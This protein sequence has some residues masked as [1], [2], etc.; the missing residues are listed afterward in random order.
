[1]LLFD[2]WL[3]PDWFSFG[4]LPG[5]VQHDLLAVMQVYGALRQVVENDLADLFATHIDGTGAPLAAARKR[6]EVVRVL[7]VAFLSSSKGRIVKSI[8]LDLLPPE[9]LVEFVGFLWMNPSHSSKMQ[10][11]D[12]SPYS[13]DDDEARTQALV[14]V[15]RLLDVGDA[16]FATEVR[17]AMEARWRRARTSIFSRSCEVEADDRR[18]REAFKALPA[19]LRRFVLMLGG[20][21]AKKATSGA[22]TNRAPTTA[23]FDI[24]EYQK[25]HPLLFVP[26]VALVELHR[27][28]AADT[29][30]VVGGLDLSD[31]DFRRVSRARNDCDVRVLQRI[32]SIDAAIYSYVHI[33]AIAAGS[34]AKFIGSG[35]WKKVTEAFER[36]NGAGL[37][38]NAEALRDG[39][40]GDVSPNFVP[41]G[42][43]DFALAINLMS[44]CRRA[45]SE[46]LRLTQA[47]RDVDVAGLFAPTAILKNI[48]S[49]PAWHSRLTAMVEQHG[50]LIQAELK[51]LAAGK[52]LTWDEQKSTAVD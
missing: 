22:A 20:E 12:N 17:T 37:Q 33:I 29:L 32:V 19:H 30:A 36:R 21:L 8:E 25:S 13:F 31:Y 39:T 41:G 24:V 45:P 4:R 40:L 38:M 14:E 49:G 27:A 11:L 28:L 43:R 50:Q 47:H 5:R 7:G 34:D 51:K 2:R 10:S 6:E 3:N 44:E 15:S 46:F 42:K 23:P 35:V 18:A 9:R 48:V 26:F 16:S 1:M 52:L